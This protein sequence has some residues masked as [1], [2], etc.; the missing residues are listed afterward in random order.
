MPGVEIAAKYFI[1]FLPNNKTITQPP[2][3]LLVFRFK[4]WLFD[5]GLPSPAILKN[6]PKKYSASRLTHSY[7]LHW[8]II[9]GGF[10]V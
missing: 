10:T 8:H 2:F 6:K 1:P 5:I 7:S 9:N 3:R 4:Y